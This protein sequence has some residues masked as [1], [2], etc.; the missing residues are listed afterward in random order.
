[1]DDFKGQCFVMQPFDGGM[2]DSLYEQVFAP[3]IRDA[4]LVPYRVDNDPSASI[5]IETIEQEIAKSLACF[6]EISENNP[7]VWFE[8]GYAI[9]CD[10]PLCLVSS[11]ARAKFPFDVQHRKIIRYPAH[12]LPKD[13]EALKKAITERLVAVVEKQESRLQ[14]AESASALA[15][16]PQTEG[17]APHELLAMTLIFEDHYSDGTSPWNLSEK[18]NKSGFKKVVSNLAATGLINK[19]FVETRHVENRDGDWDAFF[20]TDKG[21]GWLLANQGKLNLKLRT[22]AA[23]D[24]FAA[25]AE[26]S[27]DDIPF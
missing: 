26:I 1:M 12:S 7:N 8:L 16:V 20:V 2:Y 17:L 9:A 6:A 23:A 19:G 24:D 22:A 18:M 11:D 5:P 25:S 15:V 3:A 13:Y 21:T 14:N 10:K 27:D 4:K